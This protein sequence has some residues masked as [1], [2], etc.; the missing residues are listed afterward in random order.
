M[1]LRPNTA[2]P[3]AKRWLFATVLAGNVGRF[4]QHMRAANGAVEDSPDLQRILALPWRTMDMSIDDIV[5]EMSALL[6]QD[7]D[8]TTHVLRP[9]QALA[10]LELAQLGALCAPIKCGGGK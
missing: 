4:S 2:P 10:L 7:P 8:D 6:R 1:R 9:A 5:R 3:A